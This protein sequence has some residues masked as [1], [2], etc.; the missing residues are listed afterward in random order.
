LKFSAILLG[1]SIS[2]PDNSIRVPSGIDEFSRRGPVGLFPKVLKFWK[3][4]I[5]KFFFLDLRFG[6]LEE[7]KIQDSASRIL[8]INLA[9]Q[10]LGDS[11]MDL[12]ARPLLF[13]RDITLITSKKNAELYSDD[14]FFKHV[15]S[16][17]VIEQARLPQKFDLVICDSFSPRVLK[18]KLVLAPNVPYVG[19]YGFLN[20]FEVHRTYF[21]FARMMELLNLPSMEIPMRPSIHVPELSNEGGLPQVDVCLAVGGEWAFRTYAHWFEVISWLIQKGYSVSLVGSKNGLETSN[22]IVANEPRVR[23]TVGDLS[24]REVVV[25]ITKAKVFIG[26]DGGLWH[27]ACAIPKPTVVLFADCQIFNEEGNRVTRETTDMVC[28][29]LYDDLEVSNIEPGAVIAAFERLWARIEL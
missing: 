13:G 15:C 16:I 6:F 8:W 28:E 25:E 4:V 29:T 24:L 18:A 19:L 17:E 1:K 11:L 21:S 9:A 14:S 27:M 22:E 7:E 2:L 23:T 10:S 26:A 12:A 20:G 3:R 5:Y